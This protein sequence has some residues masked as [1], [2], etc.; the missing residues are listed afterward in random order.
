MRLKVV[1]PFRYLFKDEV[2]AV[3]SELGLPESIVWRHPFPG[4]GLAVR[5][6]GDITR[7]RLE[8][9]RRADAIFLDEIR[10]AGLYRDIW[11]AFAALAPG[12]RSVGVMTSRGSSSI[13]W[14]PPS[15]A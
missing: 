7:E 11:Q 14:A 2:R 12:I 1:E 5:I 8:I 6:T 15:S 13:G 3:A 10:Q 4:P 9:V